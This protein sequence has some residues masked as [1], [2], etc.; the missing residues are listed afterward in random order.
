[1]KVNCRK[2]GVEDC[3]WVARGET[4][5]DV[6]EEVVGHLRSEHGLDMPDTEKILGADFSADPLETDLE[7]G[8]MTLVT[9]LREELNIVPP[10][11]APEAGPAV[12]QVTSR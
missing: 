3:D 12:A 10:E 7:P 8:I 1:M 11:T 5:A 2:L 9:R 6:V 4:P